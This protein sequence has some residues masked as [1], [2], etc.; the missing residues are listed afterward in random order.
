M[1]SYIL[2]VIKMKKLFLLLILVGFTFGDT[3]TVGVAEFEPNI[4]FSKDKIEGF[5]IDIWNAVAD[6]MELD[7]KY[8]KHDD[9]SAMLDDVKNKKIDVAMS[10]ITITSTRETDFDFSYPYM[11]SNLAVMAKEKKIDIVGVL[12]IFIIESW[13][14]LIVFL[15]YLFIT[16]MLMWLAE[17]GQDSFSDKFFKGMFDCVYFVN[18]TTTSTG[19]GDKTP[20]TKKGKV[21][22]VVIMWIGIGIFFPYLTGQMASIITA[23]NNDEK[24][25]NVDDLRKMNPVV[26]RNTTSENMLKEKNITYTSAKSLDRC[27]RM[28]EN[29][30]ATAIVYDK[31]ILAYVDK[32]GQYEISELPVVQNYGI[33]VKDN[34]DLKKKI[35]IALLSL[36]EDGTYKDIH[37]RWYKRGK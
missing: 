16:S 35:D 36:I 25:M 29:G 28:L 19:Y 15:I 9:F 37:D 26:V 30:E 11:R 31:D 1:Q 33:A 14:T 23:Y 7:F 32:A 4:I 12:V 2:K 27:L 5:D 20:K 3:L 6:K 18:T 17:R 22:S 34:S 13:S 8:E 21:L 24:I 10:G